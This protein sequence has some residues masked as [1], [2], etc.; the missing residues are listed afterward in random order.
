MKK[1][2][3]SLATVVLFFT[4]TTAAFAGQIDTPPV[5]TPGGAQIEITPTICESETT[6]IDSLAEFALGIWEFLPSLF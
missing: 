6:T 2:G 3:R 4:L 1:A 5:P